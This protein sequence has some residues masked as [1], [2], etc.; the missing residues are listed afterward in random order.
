M[1]EMK[2]NALRMVERKFLMKFLENCRTLGE[3]TVPQF[4][5]H[6]KSHHAWIGGRR[7]RREVVSLKPM[8]RRTVRLHDGSPG[9]EMEAAGAKDGEAS[10]RCRWRWQ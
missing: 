6:S 1:Q 9:W 10:R 4:L 5:E 8:L 7:V 3:R 2:S